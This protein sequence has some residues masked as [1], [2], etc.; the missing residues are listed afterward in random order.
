MNALFL[1]SPQERLGS[2]IV[3]WMEKDFAFFLKYNYYLMIKMTTQKHGLQESIPVGC[4]PPPFVVWG[5][6]MSLPFWSHVPL[7]GICVTV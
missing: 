7:R 1:D 2:Q 4:V 5:V 6:M 3:Y